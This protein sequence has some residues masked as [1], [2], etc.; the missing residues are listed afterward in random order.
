ME[1]TDSDKVCD[2]GLIEKCREGDEQAFRMLVERHRARLMATAVGM[3]GQGVDA[4]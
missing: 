4:K 1:W 2:S 3:L